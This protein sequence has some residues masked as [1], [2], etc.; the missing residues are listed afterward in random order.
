MLEVLKRYRT[1]CICLVLALITFVVY[2]QT[3]THQFIN[4]DDDV[5]VTKNEY[6]KAGLTRQA[7][8]WAFT[9]PR[10]AFWHPVTMLSHILDCQL[11]GLNPAGHHLTN[12][13]LHIANTLLLFLVLKGMT[14]A[15][16][17]SAFV[18]ALFA[19]HPLHVESVAWVSERKDVLSTFFWFFTMAAYLRYTRR[20]NFTWYMITLLA[21]TLGL[22]AKPM[23]VTL[24]FVLLLLDWWPL[25]RLKSRVTILEKLPFFAITAVFS[26]IAFLAQ[27]T[28]GALSL[29]L[30]LYIRIANAAISYLTYIEKMFWP[31]RLAV[32]YPHQGDKISIPYA[33]FAGALILGFSACVIYLARRHKY[34]F[35]GWFWYIGTLVPVCGLIQVGSFA[36]ADRYT[37]VSLTGLFI[38]IAWGLADI[39]AKWS[40]RKIVLTI[41]GLAALFALSISTYVQLRNWRNSITLFEHALKVTTNNNTAH[42]NLACALGSQGR[43]DEAISHYHQA[44]LI[45]PDAADT[46]YSLGFAL[47]LQGK[48]DEAVTHYRQ[49]LRVKPEYANAHYSLGC[50]LQSQGKLDEAVRH[51]RQALRI[52]PDDLD[53]LS[54]LGDILASQGK[55]DEAAS[56]FHKVLHIKPDHPKANY[57]LA[58]AFQLQGKLGEAINYYHQALRIDPDSVEACS[59]LAWIL[60]AGPDPKIRDANQAVELAERAARLTQYQNATV[61]NTLAAGY[62]SVGRFDKAIT[63]ARSALGLAVAAGNEQLASQIRSQLELYNSQ[64]TWP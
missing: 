63:T 49:A 3:L 9:A 62:A 34:L 11:Y 33:F 19:L 15:L 38:I 44:L 46:H 47:Q 40:S 23:L 43:Y 22:M 39:T 28:K 48:L 30:P 5:Y 56:C 41:S 51:Y 42:Y 24:P 26:I 27:Q 52:K 2:A 61:L 45:K 21:F 13:L 50:I 12:L 58:L 16:W 6:I 35:V 37:Y 36:M 64:K 60:A 7:V 10:L 29:K 32:F 55:F 54:N 20:T 1:F 4:L 31:A 18:A 53:A 59:N 8:L 25:A 17:R 14:G 57:N